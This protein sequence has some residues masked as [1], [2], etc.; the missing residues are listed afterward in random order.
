MGYAS[1]PYDYAPPPNGYS[2]PPYPYAPAPTIGV[3]QQRPN[4]GVHLHDGLC[5]HLTAG[6]GG[7]L[8][9]PGPGS[10]LA[11]AGGGA[12][13]ALGAALTPHLVL[14]GA[15]TESFAEISVSG[16]ND[17]AKLLAVMVG[18]GPSLTYYLSSNFFFSGTIAAGSIQLQRTK[19][20]TQTWSTGAGLSVAAEIGQEWWVSDN[21]ALGVAFRGQYLR[22]KEQNAGAY[23]PVWTASSFNLLFSGTYN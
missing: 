9:S 14:M 13:V 3:S 1:P 7:F 6:G 22:A 15:I 16:A 10:D 4:P 21:W 23:P 2:Q 18:F 8:L 12:D 11:G 19:D 17:A 20:A 5:L